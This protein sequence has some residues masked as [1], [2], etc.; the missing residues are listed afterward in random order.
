MLSAFQQQLKSNKTSGPE[1]TME[2]YFFPK[3]VLRVIDMIHESNFNLK[4]LNYDKHRKNLLDPTAT[5]LGISPTVFKKPIAGSVN[6]S[7]TRSEMELQRAFN[8]YAGRRARL[9]ISDAL[10]NELPDITSEKPYIDP[11]ALHRF[12]DRMKILVK[13]AN[14]R[15]P[16]TERYELPTYESAVAMLP[17]REERYKLAI[18]PQ[19]IEVI[20]RNIS[21]YLK[22]E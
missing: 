5:W 9:F 10:S 18:S 1:E 11:E 8:I 17:S 4:I 3:Q 19:Q 22:P 6:R 16:D 7:L 21:K 13:E 2:R 12:L 15:L 14:T 20:S